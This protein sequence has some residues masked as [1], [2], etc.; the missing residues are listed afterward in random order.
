MKHLTASL[1]SMLAFVSVAARAESTSVLALART[2]PLPD[3]SGLIGPM[4]ADPIHH[5][6]FV[7]ATGNNTVEVL[8]LQGN[9]RIETITGCAKPQGI[10]FLPKPNLLYVTGNSEGELKI[11]DCDSFRAVKTIGSLPDADSIRFDAPSSRV[12]VGYGAGALGVVNA[13]SGVKTYSIALAGRPAAFEIERIGGR[14]FVNLP[15]AGAVAVVDRINRSVMATWPVKNYQG[16]VPMLLDETSHRLLIG[17]RQPSR[18]AVL[19]TTIEKAV[20]ELEISDDVDGVSYDA[21]RKRIYVSC[22]E[23]FINVV[24]QADARVYR[25]VEKLPTSAGARAGLF[26]PELD[27]YYLAV[28]RRDNRPAEIRIYQPRS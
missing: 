3:V 6:L 28:P 24:A 21:K 25:L 11:Y 23:G 16:N 10:L 9:K 20:A 19:D 5:R 13:I 15:E 26:V 4:A 17:C 27:S 12:Y 22:G 8:D 1:L 2:I 18:L 14:I 7:A